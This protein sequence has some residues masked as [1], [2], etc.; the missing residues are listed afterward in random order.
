MFEIKDIKKIRKQLG[1]TQSQLAKTSGVSQSLIAKIESGKL[2]PTYSKTQLI[3]GALKEKSQNEELK[4]KDI[5]IKNISTTS[6]STKVI[7]IIKLMKKK[8]IS[9]IPILKNNRIL[10]VITEKSILEKTITQ[11]IALLTAED[12]M[13]P[14]PPILSEDTSINI[15]QSL[16]QHFQIVLIQTNKSY[17]LISKVDILTKAI[18]K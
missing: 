15:V 7:D 8:N 10:G 6:P 5:M 9:Q 3:F 18:R 4:A 16:L 13:F 14:P 12:C 1:I 2:D 17:G 11:N